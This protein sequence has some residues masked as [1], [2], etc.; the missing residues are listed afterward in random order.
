MSRQLPWLTVVPALS[1]GVW[2]R[3]ERGA[4]VDVALWLGSWHERDIFVCGSAAMVAA[5]RERMTQAGIPAERIRCEDFTDDPYRPITDAADPL[6][7]PDE[8]RTP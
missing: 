3:A 6:A 8:V 5:T 1:H 7:Y 2:H 4:A